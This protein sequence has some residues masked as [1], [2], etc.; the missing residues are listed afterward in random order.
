MQE[1]AIGVY[2]ELLKGMSLLQKEN[3]DEQKKP[4]KPWPEERRE[5]EQE[6]DQQQIRAV[7]QLI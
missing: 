6:M 1:S 3:V 7:C 4:T 2:Q 5:L